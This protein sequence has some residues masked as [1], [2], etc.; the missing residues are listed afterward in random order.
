[1]KP[2]E[3]HVKINIKRNFEIQKNQHVKFTKMNHIIEV[4]HM[5]K[6]PTS[7]GIKKLNKNEYVNLESGEVLEFNHIENRSESYTSLRKTFKKLMYLI[8]NN[9][10]G[11]DNELF[12]TLTYKKNMTDPDQL[13]LDMKR[14]IRRVNTNYGYMGKIDYINVVE[15]QARGAWHCHILMKWDTKARVYVPNT[16]IAEMWGQGKIVKVKALREVD[17]I[18]A[19]LT[20]YLTDIPLDDYINGGGNGGEHSIE[21]K[22]TPDGKKFV[23]GARLH[24]Y[25]P[26]MNLYRC[27]KGIKAPISEYMTYKKAKE[28]VDSAKPTFSKTY[29]IT[30]DDQL[31]NQ[32]TIEQYNLLR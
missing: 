25:P 21:I 26:G 20:A 6:K 15:P 1:M 9:F 16:K 4:Q 29:E 8:N 24:M 7:P 28:K 10:T 27:S 12:I 30:T 2:I 19:Y 14:F 3:K 23:K 17:N 32:I 5:L 18:G 11:S 31:L 22:T 13:Y